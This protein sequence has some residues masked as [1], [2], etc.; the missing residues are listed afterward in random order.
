M[1]NKDTAPVFAGWNVWSVWQVKD[2][3]FSIMMLGVSRDRQLQIWVEDQVRLNAGVTVSDPIDLKGSQIQILNGPPDG[4]QVATRKENVSGP[5]MVVDGA[6]E[7]R[8]VRFYNRSDASALPW[9]HDDSYLLDSVYEPTKDNPL[10]NSAAP[11][12]ISQ[13]VGQGVT[14]PVSDLIGSIP[15]WM[16]VTA[17]GA[18]ALLLFNEFGGGVAKAARSQYRKLK[19]KT[20]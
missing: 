9:P 17:L 5:A 4:L 16:K 1:T 15:T 14:Q 19:R 10:T 20:K 3:P 2:L 11:P 13:T 6:A 8:Y 7:L 18:G 12:T